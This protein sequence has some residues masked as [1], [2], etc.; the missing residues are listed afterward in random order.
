VSDAAA[1]VLTS[2]NPI[3]LSRTPIYRFFPRRQCTLTRL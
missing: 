1:A 2:R 3:T